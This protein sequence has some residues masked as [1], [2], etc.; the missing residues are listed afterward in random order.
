MPEG[1]VNATG[2]HK[3]RHQPFDDGLPAG[4]PRPLRSASA[5]IS[6]PRGS[7]R[8]YRRNSG[9]VAM[10]YLPDAHTEFVFT[11][12]I[13]SYAIVAALALIAGIALWI[14]FR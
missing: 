7:A 1:K 5:A 8:A 4:N 6:R 9:D 2:D 3:I 13:P 12:D 10:R 11:L 14:W